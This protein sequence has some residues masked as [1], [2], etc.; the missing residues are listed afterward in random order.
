MISSGSEQLIGDPDSNSF[1]EALQTHE[2][3]TGEQVACDPY[4]NAVKA[5]RLRVHVIP[6]RA[7]SNR[8]GAGPAIC[9]LGLS[10]ILVRLG[11]ST[12]KG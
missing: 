4:N 3:L 5:L 2:N 12:L 11:A 9:T 1:I 7:T 8:V 6:S 10:L